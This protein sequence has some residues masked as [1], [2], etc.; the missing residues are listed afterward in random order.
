LDR[1]IPPKEYKHVLSGNTIL[2]GQYWLTIDN[3][4]KLVF[5]ANKFRN[6]NISQTPTYHKIVANKYIGRVMEI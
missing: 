1:I 5:V 6:L 2:T 4:V 3:E